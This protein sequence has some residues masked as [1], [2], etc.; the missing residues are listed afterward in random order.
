MLFHLTF[1]LEE[2]YGDS[3]TYISA[4]EVGSQDEYLGTKV[5]FHYWV[6]FHK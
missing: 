5:E 4:N 3:I 6:I 2:K 1:A